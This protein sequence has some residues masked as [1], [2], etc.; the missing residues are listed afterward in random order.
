MINLISLK[1]SLNQI[2][3]SKN[4][5]CTSPILS[6]LS[7]LQHT[8][9]NNQG[10]KCSSITSRRARS[11][12]LYFLDYYTKYLS[13][14]HRR[15]RNRTRISDFQFIRQIGQGGYGVIY[16]MSHSSGQLM[17][18]KK[19]K[20]KMLFLQNEIT[21]VKNERDL[22]IKSQSEWIV[23]LYY[24]FQEDESIYLAMVGYSLLNT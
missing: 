3:S 14:T 22:M 8:K 1:Y 12:H 4:Q 20:A 17:A 15:V 7:R 13:Q 11:N 24:A 19:M 10:I 5:D 21:H 9:S 16:L 23:K 6:Q 2:S 18:V